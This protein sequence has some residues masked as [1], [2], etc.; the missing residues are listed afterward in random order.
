MTDKVK[1]D[2]QSAG[3]E[4]VEEVTAPL[5][6]ALEGVAT[7]RASAAN[8]DDKAIRRTR[9]IAT[10]ILIILILIILAACIILYSMLRPGG[11]QLGD[12]NV[13][14]I[15]WIR[16]I[17]G[18][19]V[20]PDGLINPSSVF[21][22]PSGNS[23]WITDSV[24]FRLVQYDLNGRLMQIVNADWRTNNMIVPS[25]IAISPKGWHY[26]AEQTYNRV[27]IFDSDWNH[28]AMVLVEEP[29]SISAN[30]ERFAIGSRRGFAVFS[31]DGSEA[32]GM[33][34]SDG[35]DPNTHF[36]YVH[37]LYMDSDNN[38]YVLDTYNN[39]L[40]K[41]NPMGEAIFEQQLG[42]PGN[43]G[44]QGGRYVDPED[45]AEHF[46]ANMQL[47]LG[48]AM[49]AAGRI[50]I[51]DM[52][53]FSVAIIDASDGTYIRTVGQQGIQDG[54]FHNPN[55]IA[56]N[57][58]VDMFATAESS[59]GRVQ[60]FSIEGSSDN[61]LAQARR[62]LSDFLNACCIPL[63]IILIILAAYLI[64]R[65]LARKRREKEMTAALAGSTDPDSEGVV[66]AA[67]IDS[68]SVQQ[69]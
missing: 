31:Y 25:R 46:P 36:D 69:T 64:S 29:V 18:H 15:T 8:T 65:Y 12:R 63:F 35:D 52:F 67:E 9:T 26:V 28:V 1:D 34:A 47:P 61:N 13:A 10:I 55:D 41:F 56:Y 7:L 37:G 21:F 6:S 23:V 62:Q 68:T 53:N 59:L 57:P 33:H 48:I 24:R 39:R 16:S 42:F 30:D 32:I 19:G 45:A 11:L 43:A 20:D 60:L 38:T 51:I 3:A 22:D 27:N 58:H 50:N 17:Y 5:D 66:D 54:R 44:I 4:S 14:G 2:V 40:I 49:D